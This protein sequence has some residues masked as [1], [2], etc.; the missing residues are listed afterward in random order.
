[1]VTYIRFGA[2]LDCTGLTNVTVSKSLTRIGEVAFRNCNGLKSLTL[3]ST[4]T[5]LAEYVLQGCTN[6]ISLYFE[7]NAPSFYYGSRVFDGCPLVTC[8]YRPGT[9]GW[10]SS[11]AGRPAVLWNPKAQ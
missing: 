6:R 8:Y 10:G 4:V 11:F 1:S 2:F 3:P 5:N 7:G 9:T